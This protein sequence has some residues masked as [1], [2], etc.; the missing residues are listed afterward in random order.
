MRVRPI[1]GGGNSLLPA[2]L[3]ISFICIASAAVSVQ[4]LESIVGYPT[5]G[6]VT[7]TVYG[8]GFG[9]SSSGLAVTIGSTACSQAII[10]GSRITCRL[11]ALLSR[12]RAPRLC[13]PPPP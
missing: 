11:G 13:L 2:L 9:T 4:K 10:S 8:A 12:A 7:V 6:G 1:I 5:A 3:L